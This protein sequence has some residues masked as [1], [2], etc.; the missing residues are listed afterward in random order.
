MTEIKNKS[1]RR[2]PTVSI[3]MSVYKEPLEWIK[4]SIDSIL[5]QTFADF[6]F[7]I[8]NDNPDSKEL[9]DFLMLYAEKDSRIKIIRNHI[10]SGLTKSLN[11]GLIHCK[12]KYI[13]RM[14]AD[15]YSLPERLE[16]QVRYMEENPEIVA[17]SAMAHSWDGVKKLSRIYRPSSYK[18]IESYIYTSSPFIHPL[19]IIRSEVLKTNCLRYDESFKVSQDYKLAA[20][21][22]K[23][24]KIANLDKYLLLYRESQNQIS[25]VKGYLQVEA[26][27][28]VRR[29][30]I[31]NYYLMHGIPPLPEKITFQTVKDNYVAEKRLSVNGED[32]KEIM[33]CIRRVLYYS[34]ADY[35][36]AS[37]CGFLFSGDYFSKP[38][39][40][41]R[42]GIVTLKHLKADIIP[43]LV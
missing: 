27:R 10:N 36:P 15:D 8:V 14:D 22:F 31:N 20:D 25:K 18:D 24:G 39:N 11:N 21:L 29:E 38:Y 17:S 3:L 16:C 19:L 7:L 6:E 26:G 5:N 28:R 12:G 37:F 1:A 43:A 35:S 13:A 40:L 32:C 41:R 34:L 30:L 2:T 23:I 42:F 4:I 9:E 33:N